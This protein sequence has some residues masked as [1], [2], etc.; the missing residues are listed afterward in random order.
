MGKKFKEKKK[1]LEKGVS[2]DQIISPHFKLRLGLWSGGGYFLIHFK[3][4]A[5]LQVQWDAFG[6][7]SKK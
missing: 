7:C 5:M 4:L 1:R 2:C 3:L 6:R